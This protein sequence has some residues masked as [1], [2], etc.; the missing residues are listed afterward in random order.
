MS[1]TT[2]STNKMIPTFGKKNK[3]VK[4]KEKTAVLKK[5]VPPTK[6]AQHNDEQE[7]SDTA[8]N[9]DIS[10]GSVPN[11]EISKERSSKSNTTTE[12]T[13]TL[14]QD[15]NNLNYLNEQN[16]NTKEWSQ[17]QYNNNFLN[18]ASYPFNIDENPTNFEAEIGNTV[19]SNTEH[20]PK[21]RSN[22]EPNIAGLILGSLNVLNDEELLLTQNI[23]QETHSDQSSIKDLSRV[24]SFSSVTCLNKVYKN[25]D[26]KS[27][28][29]PPNIDPKTKD[30]KIPE[31]QKYLK[32]FKNKPK[33]NRSP[34]FIPMSI[35]LGDIGFD[36]KYSDYIKEVG[37]IPEDMQGDEKDTCLKILAMYPNENDILIKMKR[38]N[39]F[40]D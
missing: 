27:F 38:Y 34:E 40:C 7:K 30:Y 3:T 24:Q 5:F 16:Q 4:K 12:N 14:T 17:I 15:L 25:L 35:E 22:K 36:K 31:G 20:R 11:G 9:Q 18:L 26:V 8:E 2:L 28:E 33:K 10:D 6:K 21:K 39:Y 13:N 29:K 37:V 19:A 32:L 1:N 23:S